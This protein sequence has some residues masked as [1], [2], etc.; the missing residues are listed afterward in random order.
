MRKDPLDLRALLGVQA[1]LEDHVELHHAVVVQVAEVGLLG[2]L[3]ERGTS[4]T[5]W[6]AG[7]PWAA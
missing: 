2:L 7:R 4:G 6:P 1:E 5:G 3:T